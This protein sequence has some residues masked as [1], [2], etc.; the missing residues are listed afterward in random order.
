MM[1]PSALAT[2]QH[3]EWLDYLDDLDADFLRF[4]GIDLE[5]DD[6]SSV[7]FFALAYRTPAYGGVMTKHAEEQAEKSP[8]S[9]AAASPSEENEVSVHQFAALTGITITKAG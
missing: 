9:S 6:I 2:A 8:R 5:Q 4:Y 3:V 7:R 1:Y